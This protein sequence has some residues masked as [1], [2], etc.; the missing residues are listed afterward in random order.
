MAHR[1]HYTKE[2]LQ[3]LL[4]HYMDPGSL[5][6]RQVESVMYM[7]MHLELGTRT[8][9]ASSDYLIVCPYSRK[10]VEPKEVDLPFHYCLH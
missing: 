4:H 7:N 9:P 1:I 2:T 3:Y 6:Q 8:I 5:L 10:T